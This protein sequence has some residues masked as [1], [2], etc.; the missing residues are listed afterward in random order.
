MSS[1]IDYFDTFYEPILDRAFSLS[2]L[3]GISALRLLE[4]AKC[5]RA[6]PDE[7]TFYVEF[8][9]KLAESNFEVQELVWD[10]FTFK[11]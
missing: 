11:D 3:K 1:E 5:P 10:L 4:N 9:K 2:F 8:V 7:V 6:K